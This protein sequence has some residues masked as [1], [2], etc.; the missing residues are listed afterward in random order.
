VTVQPAPTAPAILDRL[1]DL[2]TEPSQ[3]EAEQVERFAICYTDPVVING[4]PVALTDLV[5]RARML[6]AGLADVRRTVVD[7]VEGPDRMAFAFR[8][9]GRHVGPL[10]TPLGP[11]P[12]TDRELDVLGIDILQLDG[13]GRISGISVLSGL[14]DELGA[15]GALRIAQA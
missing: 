8:L 15:A 3:D 14:M 6:Q 9:R 5:A 4:S 10:P 12:A 13:D 7:M 11:V 2:W 1:L